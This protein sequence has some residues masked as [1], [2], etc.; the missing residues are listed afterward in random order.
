MAPRILKED[1][2]PGFFIK[3]FIK[4]MRIAAAEAD[5]KGLELNILNQVLEM[6]ESLEKEG[7]GELGTQA[8]IKY[9]NKER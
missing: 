3:H 2:A 6:Y 5:E 7:A 1:Y 8:L 9:Y 4:D